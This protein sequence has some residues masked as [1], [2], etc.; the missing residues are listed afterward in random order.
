M[1]SI[2][3][4]CTGSA[5]SIKSQIKEFKK[6]SLFPGCN[7]FLDS[8]TRYQYVQRE[9]KEQEILKTRK[10][11]VDLLEILRS[12]VNSSSQQQVS[13]FSKCFNSIPIQSLTLISM[14]SELLAV[15]AIDPSSTTR[16]AVSALRTVA[17]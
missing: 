9:L 4:E 15:A 5:E 1:L 2:P 6:M 12:H 11:L 17:T 14:T 8:S 13:I 3:G 7:E 10:E 16:A